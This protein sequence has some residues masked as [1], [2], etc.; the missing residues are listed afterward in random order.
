MK[1]IKNI[2]AL[3]TATS[4][5]YW[6]HTLLCYAHDT[7][8]S[9]AVLIPL[10]A[11]VLI[12]MLIFWFLLK[13]SD[14]LL[15]ILYKNHWMYWS[16]VILSALIVFYLVQLCW[17]TKEH[18]TIVGYGPWIEFTHGERSDFWGKS[19]CLKKDFGGAIFMVAALSWALVNNPLNPSA[20]KTFLYLGLFFYVV[21]GCIINQAE[22]MY[23]PSFAG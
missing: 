11:Y 14:R 2:T 22:H 5:L 23:V 18:E 8:P 16:L 19:T 7:L 4:F 21:L 10:V 6:G 15:A 20:R 17:F 13:K 9:L 1:L 3:F 12:S